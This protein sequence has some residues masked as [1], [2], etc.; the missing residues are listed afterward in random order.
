M[1][2]GSEKRSSRTSLRMTRETLLESAFVSESVEDREA[3][4]S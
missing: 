3:E 2:A 1:N 4:L